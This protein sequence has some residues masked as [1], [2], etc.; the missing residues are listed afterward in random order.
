MFGDLEEKRKE[1]GVQELCIMPVVQRDSTL[2]AAYIRGAYGH[3][4]SNLFSLCQRLPPKDLKL[5]GK[6]PHPTG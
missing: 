3:R 2:Y 1:M 6:H 5:F 4:T